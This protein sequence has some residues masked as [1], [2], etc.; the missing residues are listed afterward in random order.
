ME[1]S[2]D[3]SSFAPGPTSYGPASYDRP[4]LIGARRRIII[5]SFAG[6]VLAVAAL[7]DAAGVLVLSG[8]QWVTAT[9][10]VTM[11][12]LLP[13]CCLL[14]PRRPGANTDVFQPGA[15]IIVFYLAYVIGPG[16]YAATSLNYHFNWAQREYPGPPLVNATL[17]LFLLGLVSFGFGYR[18]PNWHSGRP[19]VRRRDAV[20]NYTAIAER[21]PLVA[22]VFLGI[23]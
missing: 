18:L 9:E 10:F 14:P 5:F 8:E 1:L 19:T 20:N 2:N 4:H 3:G 21:V 16:V 17:G 6:A 7:L 23:G 11:L 15:T 22:A 12:A 13:V